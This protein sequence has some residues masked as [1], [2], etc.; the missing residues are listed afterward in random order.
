MT[1]MCLTCK[2]LFEAK[3]RGHKYCDICSVLRRKKKQ[4][5]YKRRYRIDVRTETRRN[6]NKEKLKGSVDPK[7]LVRGNI[8]YEGLPT[9]DLKDSK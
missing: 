5:E 1:K 9:L 3:G 2:G 7:F 4:A 8:H 6:K